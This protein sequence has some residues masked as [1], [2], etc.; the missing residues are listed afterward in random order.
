MR[1]AL[2]VG[3]FV[4]AAALPASDPARAA[5]PEEDAAE[6]TGPSCVRSVPIPALDNV[7]DTEWSP[8]GS[9]LALVRTVRVPS[10][11]N[12]SGYHELEIL[13]TLDLRTGHVRFF[14]EGTRPA[15]SASG[16]YLSY[17]GYE[18]DF[19]IVDDG[20]RTVAN[21]T[22]T[23]PEY[24]WMGDALVY[25]ERSTMRTWS[26]EASTARKLDFADIPH[27]P[28]D[29][30]YWSADGTRYTHT[31]Y[32][33][34]K[35]EPERFLGATKEGSLQ[36]LTVPGAWFTE[37]SPSG[38]DLL[39]RYPSRIEIRDGTGLLKTSM[40]VPVRAL[41]QWG[42][43][44]RSLLLR[45][46]QPPGVSGGFQEIRVIWPAESV[47]TLPELEGPLGFGPDGGHYSGT[48]RTG[49]HER[50][51]VIYRCLHILPRGEAPV[52]PPAATLDLR[53][54]RLIRPVQGPISAFMQ[55]G[56]TGI[57]IGAG[58]GSPIVASDDGV[59]RAAGWI[60]NGGHR[61]CVTHAAGLE[62][63]YFH[64]SGI[65]ATVGQRV[66]RGEPIALIG[67]SGLA[68]G[69]H[70]HWEARFL[71]RLTDPLLR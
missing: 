1:R 26:A 27:F 51:L 24:R 61:V 8:D 37:W 42:P 39:V 36:P 69:P 14:G 10:T 56:H 52:A 22:P 63:C 47:M 32:D 66:R 54:G 58:L 19:L 65:L 71:G 17:W 70:V 5:V 53:D 49:R 11:D 62:T 9:R 55:G 43:G 33:S 57:D 16:R 64:A 23:N 34:T 41:H 45:A 68:G 30:L 6:A 12:V 44:G 18:A 31:R 4:V 40:P 2:L 29:H 46:A 59:V 15:W 48:V 50:R 67:M 60:T 35:P 25:L 3:A 20:E 13:E 21:L 7:F 28:A 38:A